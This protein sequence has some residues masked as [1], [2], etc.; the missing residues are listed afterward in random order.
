M[1]GGLGEMK[2]SRGFG[3]GKQFKTH[4]SDLDIRSNNSVFN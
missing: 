2:G 1:H 3:E 4:E